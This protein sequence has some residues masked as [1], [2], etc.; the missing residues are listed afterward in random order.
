MVE[1]IALG[2]GR[3]R[4]RYTRLK[5]CLVWEATTANLSY[6]AFRTPFTLYFLLDLISFRF[7]VAEGLKEFV[8][9]KGSHENLLGSDV[10]K[11][12]CAD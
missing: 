8:L 10:T 11:K 3:V 6:P 4:H 9:S 2:T 7:Y 5:M 12:L 1:I